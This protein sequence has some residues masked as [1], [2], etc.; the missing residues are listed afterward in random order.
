MPAI[1]RRVQ[2]RSRLEDV[3]LR[4]AVWHKRLLKISSRLGAEETP[5]RVGGGGK[6]WR[7]GVAVRW[8]VKIRAGAGHGAV[9]VLYRYID[10]VKL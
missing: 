5:V 3:T 7:E 2:G 8:S 9:W 1:R 10:S 6:D 4:S